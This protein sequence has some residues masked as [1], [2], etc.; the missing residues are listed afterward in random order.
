MSAETH[1][2][3]LCRGSDIDA[4]IARLRQVAPLDES[5][6]SDNIPSNGTSFRSLTDRYGIWGYQDGDGR[7]AFHWAVALKNFD[8]AQT[9]MSPPYSSP[10]LTEDEEW[11]TPFATACSVG[12][13]VELLQ[14]ILDKSMAEFVKYASW[15]AK[16]FPSAAIK[17]VGDSGT[18][19]VISVDTTDGKQEGALFKTGVR[20]VSIAHDATAESI[21][22]AIVNSEEATGLTPLLLAAGRA[23]LDIARFLVT[24]GADLNHQNDRGQSALHRAVNRGNAALV[25]YLVAVSEKKN[26]TNKAAQRRFMDLQDIHGD[27]ALFYASLDNNEEMGRY[28]LRHG[29]SRDLRNRDG[30]NFWEV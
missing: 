17:S 30:K 9:L 27:S 8:L 18:T 1:L 7:T 26:G 20:G 2:S 28:L 11:T 22:F 23:H 13:P 5:Q 14:A 6:D 24:H 29:A 16:H 25:E 21:M 4:I 15:K 3:E 10:V 19:P 12:A